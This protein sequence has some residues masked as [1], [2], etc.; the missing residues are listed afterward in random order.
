LESVE[1]STI[2]PDLKQVLRSINRWQISQRE[3]SLAL[4]RGNLSEVENILARMKAM[5]EQPRSE[6]DCFEQSSLAWYW[7]KTGWLDEVLPLLE[8]RQTRA[9]EQSLLWDEIE[10]LVQLTL[11]Y[12]ALGQRPGAA[13]SD[14]SRALS[15]ME[16]AV[17]IAKPEGF[18]RTF[19]LGG[20][21]AHDLLAELL[22][23]PGLADPDY[24]RELLAAFPVDTIEDQEAAQAGK[25]TPEE[26]ETAGEIDSLPD[27]EMEILRLLASGNTYPEIA[28][29]LYLS[30]N[31]VKTHVKRLYVR[32]GVDNRLAAIDLARKRGLIR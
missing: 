8:K 20:T 12:Q 31:T 25:F 30:V 14:H 15:F 24:I 23:G 2:S 16:Q 18:V 19:L 26:S 28:A 3:I 7:I 4:Q 27:R 10:T 5:A 29:V 11:V 1:A 6:A 17:T 22:L 13:R 21:S 9:K 32:L